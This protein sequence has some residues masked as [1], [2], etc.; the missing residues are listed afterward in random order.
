MT[1]NLQTVKKFLIVRFSSIGDI[2][3]TTPVI[4]CIRRHYPGSEIH[5]LTKKAFL[6][7]LRHNPYLD[8]I[9]LL[10]NNREE[11]TVE[12]LKEKYDLLIDLHHNLRTYAL[13]RSLQVESASFNKLNLQKWLMVNLRVNMLPDVHIVDRYLD[14]VKKL[15]VTNDF[16]GLDYFLSPGDE[17]SAKDLPASHHAGYIAIVIGATYATKKL[18]VEKLATL[19]SMIHHPI[20]LLGGNTDAAEGNQI[21]AQDDIKIYNACGKFTLNESAYL[22]KQAKLVISHDTGLMHMAA[23]F[24]KP[25]ISIWGNTVPEFGMYPYYGKPEV[26]NHQME[27]KGLSCRPCSKIGFNKCPKKHFKCMM[28]QDMQQLAELISRYLQKPS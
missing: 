17:V 6:P 11:L 4:R 7:V 18:P 3:L 16:E 19:C 9:Y 12:L 10:D 20:I 26:W 2:V 14:T 28:N 23:A 13:R 24:K 15:G 25:V 27:V 5:Y 21:A 1:L 22:V 8:K